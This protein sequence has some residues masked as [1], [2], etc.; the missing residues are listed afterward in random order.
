MRMPLLLF[1][2][3]QAM[4]SQATEWKMPPLPTEE[5]QALI[6]L[7]HSTDGQNWKKKDGWLG[8]S[9]TECDWFGISCTVREDGSPSVW[10]IE[11]EENNLTG[12][13]PESLNRFDRLESLFLQG[14]KL[15]GNLPTKILERWQDGPLHFLGYGSQFDSQISEISMEFTDVSRCTNYRVTFRPSG[16]AQLESEKCRQPHAKDPKPYCQ[17]Q[18]GYSSQFSDDFDRLCWLL[19]RLDFPHL[20]SKYWRSMTHGGLYVISV[21][22]NGRK[23]TLEDYGSYAPVSVWEIKRIISGMASES[24]WQSEESKSTC[25]WEN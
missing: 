20:S 6:N 25:S 1:L 5:R 4:N 17:V 9:G 13:L 14:N 8:N 15:T 2:I 24:W 18:T 11:L 12:S 10:G 3:F 16:F 7:Y 23:F 19:N 22:K 21:V